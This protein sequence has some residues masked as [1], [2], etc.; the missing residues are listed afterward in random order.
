MR[1]IRQAPLL[2]YIHGNGEVKTE[3]AVKSERWPSVITE[4]SCSPDGII[5]VQEIKEEGGTKAFGILIQGRVKGRDH[6]CKS[7]CYLL[8]TTSVDDL[9]FICSR[10]CLMKAKSFTESAFSQLKSCWLVD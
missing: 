8:K 2:V 7:T 3:K 10:Y 9:G 1:N 5:L 6:Q 4:R